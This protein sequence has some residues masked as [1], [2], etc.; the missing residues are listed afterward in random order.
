MTTPASP[1]IGSIST[2][3][4]FGVDRGLAARPGRRTGTMTK[5]GVNGPKPSRAS[6]SS[7]KPTIVVVRPWKLPAATM[8]L[9]WSAGDALDLVAPL[10]GDL[11]RGLDGLGAGVHR[12]HQV[13]AA[14]VAERGGEVGELV[15]HEGPAGQRELVEL[16]VR[17][18]EQ[19]R[20][21][22]AE[23]ERRVAGEQV[24]VAAAVD[25]GHP[26]ALGVGDHH[27]Q[28]VVVVRGARLGALELARPR[29]G[30]LGLGRRHGVASSVR[31]RLSDNLVRVSVAAPRWWCHPARS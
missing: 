15:V 18:G 7:E 2:A 11:D 9:A 28:R 29:V 6:G 4:V 30:L 1:W 20:V 13:L 16:G 5:P 10:A 19:R 21:A 24:E 12:Q 26:G 17:G 8:I 31:D 27:R 23:V 25:V 3:T 14:Q 22:V